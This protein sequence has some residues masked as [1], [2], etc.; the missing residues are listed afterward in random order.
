M[1][2]IASEP[3]TY[4]RSDWLAIPTNTILMVTPRMNVLL[5]PIEDENKTEPMHPRVA[6]SSELAA[7]EV[8]QN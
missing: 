5:H 3:L 1:V 6:W 8:S 2:M 7:L 4:E